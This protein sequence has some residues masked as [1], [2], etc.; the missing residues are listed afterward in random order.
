MI[1]AIITLQHRRR[2][3][4]IATRLSAHFN[5][6]LLDRLFFSFEILLVLATRSFTNFIIV[7][8]VCSIIIIIV[9]ITGNTIKNSDIVCVCRMKTFIEYLNGSFSRLGA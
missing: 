8:S 4:V 2:S 7:V 5:I 9:I 6:L 1:T 3:L